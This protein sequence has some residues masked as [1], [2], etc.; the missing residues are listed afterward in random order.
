MLFGWIGFAEAQGSAN[1]ELWMSVSDDNGLVW[2]AP[3]NLT[4]SYTPDC[5]PGTSVDC[6]NDV[7]P[8]VTRYGKQVQ[9]GEDWSG[10]T[11]VDPSGSYAGDHYLDVQYIQ[12]PDPGASVQTEGGWALANVDSVD[13]TISGR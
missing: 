9:A 6:G 12:D 11:V 10:S 2:D 1:G 7:W 5:G 3:R 8:S 4:N 13:I